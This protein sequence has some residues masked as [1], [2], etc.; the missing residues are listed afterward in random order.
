[1]INLTN[2]ESLFKGTFMVV[3]RDEKSFKGKDGND[4]RFWNITL[5]NGKKA[6]D[7]TCGAKSA[8]KEVE[9]FKPFDMEM[10]VTTDS[11][12]NIKFQVLEVMSSE[13]LS[14]RKVNEAAHK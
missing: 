9:M 10:S 6:I 14:E 3:A 13:N 7:A 8:L 5:S 1:M 12:G 2:S 11:R 4:V